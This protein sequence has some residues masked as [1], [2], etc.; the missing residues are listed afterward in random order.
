VKA[1][2]ATHPEGAAPRKPTLQQKRAAAGRVIELVARIAGAGVLAFA[3]QPETRAAF[4]ALGGR[5]G[6]GA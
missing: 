2:E 6:Q 4:A 1:H 3:D 5:K